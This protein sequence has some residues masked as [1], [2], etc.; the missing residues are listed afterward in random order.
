M[1]C[2][3]TRKAF[4]ECFM[5]K[6]DCRKELDELFK[7]IHETQYYFPIVPPIKNI[8]SQNKVFPPSDDSIP[9]PHR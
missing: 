9:R 4:K 2:E 1:D 6:T 3:D 8:N 5:V 7:C